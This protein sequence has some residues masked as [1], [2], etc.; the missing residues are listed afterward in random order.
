MIELS[1]A[2]WRQ[3]TPSQRRW[4]TA[5]PPWS[6]CLQMQRPLAQTQGLSLWQA[7]AQVH[8]CCRSCATPA[9]WSSWADPFKWAVQ[10]AT[11]Q[12]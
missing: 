4:T 11:F 12:R 3:S 1:Q 7:T 6:G 5:T 2:G 8:V 9:S 10:V